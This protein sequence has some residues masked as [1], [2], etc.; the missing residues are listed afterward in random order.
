MLTATV[1]K[2]LDFVEETHSRHSRLE[3]LKVVSASLACGYEGDADDAVAVVQLLDE[4]EIEGSVNA[5]VA[6]RRRAARK[7][8][9]RG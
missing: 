7:R 9:S 8:R 3:V 5:L 1:S 6:Q 2:E 4:L